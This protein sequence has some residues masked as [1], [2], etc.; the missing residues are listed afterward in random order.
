MPEPGD[1]LQGTPQVRSV[2]TITASITFTET[3]EAWNLEGDT[4]ANAGPRPIRILITNDSTVSCHF[5][6]T[7]EAEALIA[8]LRE[9]IAK[10]RGLVL[11][12]KLPPLEPN[13][14]R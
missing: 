8:K 3:T 7:E 9:V 11:T 1:E 12:D 10:S 13:G 6:S 4:P 14:H 2:A 5:L